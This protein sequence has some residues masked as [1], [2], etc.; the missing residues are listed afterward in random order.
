MTTLVA[1]RPAP[2]PAASQTAAD[3]WL[4]VK[5]LRSV[6]VLSA[7]AAAVVTLVLLVGFDGW[8]Y[9]RTPR[10]VRGYERRTPSG[11]ALRSRSS[12]ACRR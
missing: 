4:P 9:Y 6:L 1:E 3:A 10:A 8:T 11:N 7:L 5:A 2:A 12:I